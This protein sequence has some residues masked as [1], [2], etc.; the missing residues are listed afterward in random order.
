MRECIILITH[1][2]IIDPRESKFDEKVVYENIPTS[3]CTFHR[4]SNNFS[5][6][7]IFPKHVT[8]ALCS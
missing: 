7:K 4:Y 2:V 8:E 6:P 5:R 1:Y 3:C